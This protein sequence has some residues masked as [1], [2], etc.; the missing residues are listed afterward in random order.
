[1]TDIYGKK[2]GPMLRYLESM[3]ASGGFMPGQAL[4][5]LRALSEQFGVSRK[6]AAQVQEVLAERGLVEIRHGSGTYVLNRRRHAVDRKIRIAVIHEGLNMQQAYCAHVVAG[7]MERAAELPDCRIDQ[8]ALLGFQEDA[9]DKLTRYARMSDA[10]LLVGGYDRNLREVPHCCPA[11]G[12][13]MGS[14]FNGWVSILSLDPFDAAERA[15]QYFCD[16]N[17]HHLHLI[18]NPVDPLHSERKDIMVRIWRQH[19]TYDEEAAY[20][21]DDPSHGWWFSGGTGYN[22][23][24]LR[25][26]NRYKQDF[27]AAHHALSLDGKAYI[28]PEGALM[29]CDAF[30]T[31]WHRLGRTALDEA[32]RRATTPGAPS[33]RILQGCSSLLT[34]CNSYKTKPTP[35]GYN[36]KGGKPAS[37]GS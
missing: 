37:S 24:A 20:G 3:L 25:Y 22:R 29:K 19:G 26:K 6:V 36:R 13:E 33:Q 16:R 2:G 15:T 5:T 21:D 34:Y 23:F 11:V 17:V 4:P 27:A 9:L 18:H 12:V 28:L 32:V 35:T 1:M 7:I 30:D 8:W 14:S 31:D 10:I